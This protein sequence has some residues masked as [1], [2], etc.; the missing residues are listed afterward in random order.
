MTTGTRGVK[1]F[2]ATNSNDVPVIRS[3]YFMTEAMRMYTLPNMLRQDAA[4]MVPNGNMKNKRFESNKFAPIVG[5]N[6]LIKGDGDTVRLEVYHAITGQP[7][8]CC[9]IL[10]GSEEDMTWADFEL[11]INQTRHGVNVNCTMDRQRLGRSAMNLAQPLL[12]EWYTTL[13]QERMLYH[14]AGARGH[15]Y[16]PDNMILPLDTNPQFASKMVNCVTAPTFCR[17]FYG[18]EAEGLDGSCGTAIAQTDIF[19]LESLT[20]LKTAMEE[21]AHP[22]LPI[23]LEEGGEPL[24]LL[25]VTPRQWQ[26]FQ[27][28]TDGKEWRLLLANAVTRASSCSNHPL[29]KGDCLMYENILVKKYSNPVRFLPGKAVQVANDDDGATTHVERLDQNA[30]FAVDRAMLIGGQALA[31]AYGSVNDADGKNLGKLNF[32]FWQ[33]SWDGGDKSRV[34]IK[35]I[36]GCKKIRFPSRSGVVY[37]RGVAVLDTAVPLRNGRHC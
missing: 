10:E 31:E 29:F 15:Y 11:K 5:V 27:K 24:Y 36:G 19:N 33:D 9:D 34:H 6:D 22:L 28:S 13:E 17:Q 26:T 4:N 32:H 37:D 3:Q 18:G 14:L 30:K 12:K 23:R 16:N 8:M 1:T 25:L 2:G 35:Y 20:N 21:A 7:T